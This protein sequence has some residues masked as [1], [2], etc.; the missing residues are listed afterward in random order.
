MNIKFIE[1]T[2]IRTKE[3][4]AL[5]KETLLTIE[6]GKKFTSKYNRSSHR[7][8]FFFAK[9]WKGKFYDTKHVETVVLM[10]RKGRK[11]AISRSFGEM[12]DLKKLD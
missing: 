6:S 5:S 11:I 12:V 7:R 1:H 3:R 10:S 9:T 4:G 8:N 2:E